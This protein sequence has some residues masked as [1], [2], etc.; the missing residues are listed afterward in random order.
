MPLE[1][2]TLLLERYRIQRVLGQGGFGAVY[3]AFDEILEQPCAVKENRSLSL[4]GGRQFL[5]EA[6]LLANLRHPNLP[7]V[8]HHFEIGKS[9]FLVMDFVEGED[10]AQRLRRVGRLPPEEVLRWVRQIGGAL[11]Y[12]HG[13]APPVFHRDIKP[14]NI[15]IN[16]QGE[17]IL[18][19]FGIAK[20]AG[21]DQATSTGAKGVSPGYAPPEQYGLGHTD[22]R[23]DVYALGATLY[24]LLT[25]RSPPDSVQRLLGTVEL[26]SP[27]TITPDLPPH[28][29]RAIQLAMRPGK[30][31]RLPDVATLSRL[32]EDPDLTWPPPQA[33]EQEQEAARAAQVEV[34]LQRN[35][36]R[37]W[38]AAGI[39][40]V[41]VS[42]GIFVVGA[43]S[44]LAQW[45]G[46]ALRQ[47]GLVAPGL[48]AA[49]AAAGSEVAPLVRRSTT[50]PAARPSATVS[51]TVT[52]IPTPTSVPVMAGTGNAV[53][54][55]PYGAWT[56]GEPSLIF[57]LA[58]DGE[59][60]AVVRGQG[61]DLVDPVTGEVKQ[62]LPPFLVS[63]TAYALA[64]R[65]DTLLV[66]VAGEILHW[67][68]ASENL[69]ER[70]PIPGRDLRLSPS[71]DLLAVRDKYIMVLNLK[72]GQRLTSLGEPYSQQQFAISPD[73]RTFALTDGLVVA[74]W[75]LEQGVMERR[76]VG[77]GEP[78][79]G[80]AFTRDGSRLVSASGD[81]WDMASGELV[82]VF[83]S[84]TDQIA[85][86][87]NGELII[88]RDGSVWDLTSGEPIGQIPFDEGTPG[89]LLFTADGRFLIRH[90]GATAQVWVVDPG[91]A[92]RAD[93]EPAAQ[94]IA[95][96]AIDDLNL[97]RLVRGEPLDEDEY[98]G[99]DVSPNGRAVAAWHGRLLR[100][101]DLREEIPFAEF[102]VA[103]TVTDAAFL[104]D[105]FLA[106]V[107]GGTRTERWEVSSARRMQTY[108]V[109][110][111]AIG[112][113][114]AGDTFAVRS[115]YIQ[116]VE[117]LS[118][119]VVLSL[120]SAD[121]GQDFV[122]T[123]D[124][125]QL[126][127]AAGPGVGVWDIQTGRLTRQLAGH[128][129]A[130]TGLRV[131]PDGARVAA[132]SGDV[133]DLVSG[134]L[135][136]SFDPTA[137]T[138][139]LSGDG[140]LVIDAGGAVWNAT[141]GFLVGSL[142][143]QLNQAA[144]ALGD[145]TLVVLGAGRDLSA[146]R[147]TAL[148]AQT[149]FQPS[150]IQSD[151]PGLTL[152]NVSRMNL[153]GWW[154]KDDLLSLRGRDGAAP[155][156]VAFG[157]EVSRALA[158]S[159][160]GVTV[161]A[162][163]Q[164]GIDLLDPVRG[165]VV[166]S[167][168]MMLNPSWVEGIAYAG[169]ELLV[170]KG[171]AG[172]ERWDL[173]GQRLRQRY[174]IQAEAVGASP[175][176]KWIA[177]Q[178]G[179]RLQVIDFVSGETLLRDL[180]ISTGGQLFAFTP[181]S[182]LLAVA[183]GGFVDVWDLAERRRIQILR[184][185]ESSVG[186]LAFAPDGSRLIAASGT[187]WDVAD[188]QSL[189]EFA[190]ASE[191]GALSADGSLLFEGAG[192]VWATDSG[193]RRATLLDLRAPGDQVVL[194]GEGGVLVLRTAEGRLYVWSA[195]PLAPE[196]TTTPH[197]QAVAASNA[198]DLQ[199]GSHLGRGRLREALWSPDDTFLAVNTTLNA[200]VYE[201][202]TLSRLQGFEGAKVV[203]FDADENALVGGAAPL[204]RIDS[205][206]GE[207]LEDFG[208]TGIRAAAYSPDGAWLALAGHVSPESR[209]DGVA[210]IAL[211]D[212]LL[213]VLE[214]GRNPA[215]VI[216]RLEFTPDS[217]RLVASHLLAV[218]IWEVETGLQ[219]RAPIQ[220]NRRRAVL[221]PD[222]TRIGYLTPNGILV[223]ELERGATLRL[224]ADGTD[225]WQT[226]VDIPR[227]EPVDIDFLGDTTLVVFYRRVDRNTGE[228]V[229]AIATLNLQNMTGAMRVASL[230]DLSHTVGP[231]TEAYE[232]ERPQ[233]IP[234][235]GLSPSGTRVYSL[236]SDG[237]VRVASLAGQRLAET[238]PE[239]LDEMALS[240]DGA[241][242]VVP[243]S[244]GGLEGIDLTTGQVV[245]RV[246]GSWYPRQL[247]FSSRS[248]LTVLQENGVV[249]QVDVEQGR[250][251]ESWAVEGWSAAD[252]LALSPDGRLVAMFRRFAGDNRVLVFSLS[253]ERPLLDL[254]RFPLPAEPAFA[255]D[256]TTLAMMRREAV[257]LWDLQRGQL[258]SQIDGAGDTTGGLR[259]APN[260]ENLINGRGEI[261]ATADGDKVGSVEG[262][263]GTFVVSP[264]G[265]V[266]IKN[267][268]TLWDAQDGRSLGR[269]EGVLSPAV[270][271]AFTP[272]GR[273]LLWMRA[274][275][276]VEIWEIAP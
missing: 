76:L 246:P 118:G 59:T 236:T 185:Q 224:K 239:F 126:L 70:L 189:V 202:E 10:L 233:V 6:R 159:P 167:Y 105:E 264:N 166:A 138:I 98:A 146:Y 136:A 36:D 117:S 99:F 240:P 134:K 261:W 220:G 242:L 191:A 21:P 102:S 84:A 226:G 192:G 275:G 94:E 139:A 263:L 87:P 27:E 140:R 48:S 194:T 223:E 114:P 67:D 44:E 110:G 64:H 255:P 199:R 92:A 162:L 152:E 25:D 61:V 197:P 168:R 245:R 73:D 49:P 131:T 142:E 183:R 253:P 165:T 82:A 119:E 41:L 181:D 160:D 219:V 268:G 215:N 156:A 164:G 77:H 50:S 22:A 18:V 269:L 180:A 260:G 65:G 149:A 182:R 54:W 113:S 17:A 187:V 75:D 128:G 251:V 270:Q 96:E 89:T 112:A 174:E 109:G 132:A 274:G 133:W 7:R 212:G 228:S 56:S 266:L 66:G 259:F 222:G 221:S 273:R 15:K 214:S 23:T 161:T 237:I 225:F 218:S 39:C 265:E 123:P 188:G 173:Q 150:G 201:A 29:V 157:L 122:F 249:S 257:E 100:V 196:A 207:V 16:P 107:V 137:K 177:V 115:K 69:V 172:V 14:S 169:S 151:L 43:R 145:R 63:R 33:A 252:W 204:T 179:S 62:A 71:G 267:D 125:R 163:R 101:F 198:A 51:P 52:S 216:E 144:F 37:G 250:V 13:L 256:G 244:L 60:A 88:G 178:H 195:R 95:G 2:G 206:T 30:E 86:S 248:I 121:A 35:R 40:I 276:V 9:Q 116:V 203:G 234:A 72:S 19:D 130:V 93:Q 34:R 170:A 47:V 254:G 154:G 211:A 80:L 241:T 209:G 68:V 227:L 32:L 141:T 5:K 78:T 57:S 90:V 11:T 85:L 271:M 232:A 79:Q 12:L 175:D 171:R 210:L 26:P 45:V 4:E 155:R 3:L 103:G 143:V 108:A 247:A 106:V 258:R 83:D 205:R 230:M 91:A 120:G 186:D 31:D 42:T 46:P 229:A 262:P 217:R 20:E 81:V 111:E 190:S 235:F 243:D 213:R 135:L 208:L 8:T 53:A 129:P 74:L 184:S 193:E 104:G 124:G 158:P 127:I 231:Y 176:R 200:I 238:E 272:D 97:Y 24:A 28:V 148:E 58:P 38:V 153:L 55:R 1:P 147:P